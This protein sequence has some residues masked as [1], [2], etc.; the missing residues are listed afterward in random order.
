MILHGATGDHKSHKIQEES[1]QIS[2]SEN[3]LM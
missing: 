3:C 2:F 1:H